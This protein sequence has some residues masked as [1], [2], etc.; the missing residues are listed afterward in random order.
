MGDE[1]PTQTTRDDLSRRLTK[2][3]APQLEP[4]PA[5]ATPHLVDAG[6]EVLGRGATILL[7]AATHVER[8]A[9]LERMR[10]RGD[11]PHV[12]RVYS[13]AQ[14]YYIGR[15]GSVDVVLTTCRAGAGSRDG[16]TIV[17]LEAIGKVRPRGVVAIGMAFGGYTNKLKI[18]DVLVSTRVIPYEAARIQEAGNISRGGEHD[19]GA[20]LLNRFSE[21]RG[22]TFPRG[23]GYACRV[24]DGPMLS[25]EKVVDSLRFKTDLF[26][27]H[28]QAIGGEMEGSGVHASSARRNLTEWIV[29]KAVCDWGDGSKNDGYQALAASTAV[30]LV[31][32]VFTPPKVL[33][34]LPPYAD[35]SDRAGPITV[36]PLVV[37]NVDSEIGTQN[38]IQGNATFL[39][40]PSSDIDGLLSN[41][42]TLLKKN[43]VPEAGTA[44]A[45]ADKLW[46]R[47]TTS[48]RAL[49]RAL[50]ARKKVLLGDYEGAAFDLHDASKQDPTGEKSASR[51][52]QALLL[53]D[54]KDE[55]YREAQV[56]LAASP[57]LPGV[58]Y[59]LIH[60][61][62]P[63][64]ETATLLPAHW[65]D[66]P[67]SSEVAV[68][69]FLREGTRDSALAEK[70]LR[71]VRE[72]AEDDAEYWFALG[73]TIENRIHAAEDRGDQIA[74]ETRDELMRAFARA[75][76]T[77]RGPD[78]DQQRGH[79]ALAI[80]V[81]A[82]RLGRL[83]ECERWFAL[84]K[85]LAPKSLAIR[86][87]RA[88]Q[89]F[90]Q[91]DYPTASSLLR[92]VVKSSDRPQR[93]RLV[94]A[95]SLLEQGTPATILEACDILDEAAS[96]ASDPVRDRRQAALLLVET[97]LDTDLAAAAA[98]I[99][100]HSAILRPYDADRLRLILAHES[101]G[102]GAGP[103]AAQM[104]AVR[105]EYSTKDLLDFGYVLGRLGLNVE[106]IEV[107]E[108]IAPRTELEP[109]TI[110]L[111]NAANAV[112]RFE[113]V[114]NI[115][116]S[117]RSVG[118]KD[119][120]ITDGE[121]TALAQKGDLTGALELGQR[122]M[123]EHPGDRRIRL[124][125][126]Q[127]AI[128]LGHFELLPTSS[129]ELPDVDT[130]PPE[131]A[132]QVVQVLRAANQ[133]LEAERLAYA[134]YKRRRRDKWAWKAVSLAGLPPERGRVT[135]ESDEGNDNDQDAQSV[136]IAGPGT[137]VRIKD[138]DSVRWIQVE[139][140]AEFATAEDE[141]AP[142]DPV[143]L[144][145][146]GKH[147]GD[148]VELQKARFGFPATHAV[149]EEIVSCFTRTWRHCNEQYALH[150]A[151]PSFVFSFQVPEP[152]DKLVEFLLAGAKERQESVASALRTYAERTPPIYLLADV[153]N[154]SVFEITP[155]LISEQITVHAAP[156][157]PTW[158]AAQDAL[159]R[160]KKIVIDATA[161]ATITMLG[162]IETS[163]TYFEQLWIARATLDSLRSHVVEAAANVAA[164]VDREIDVQGKGPHDWARVLAT[165]ETWD[166]FSE[167]E[168]D[169]LDSKSWDVWTKVAGAGTAE[170]VHR[171]K[172]LALPLW[173][174]DAAIARAATAEGVVVISTQAV[175]EVLEEA[176]RVDAG[177]L[178]EVGAAL[179]GWRFEPTRST[180]ASYLAATRLAKWDPSAR[181]LIQ[182]MELLTGLDAPASGVA[183]FTSEI[184]RL[185]WNNTIDRTAVDGLVVA[186]LIR[187]AARHDGESVITLLPEAVRLRFGL[188]VIGARHVSE[189][190]VGW[191]ETRFSHA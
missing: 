154:R 93:S 110:A 143:A 155:L 3:E 24:V 112:E 161:I 36:A 62:P 132:F 52:I 43:L 135:R 70:L 5:F 6:D 9:V 133:H 113:L 120:Q 164:C 188:D 68:A 123:N 57:S 90:N 91:G 150:F 60:A 189:V 126:S 83:E 141:F 147:V 144:A 25:G 86:T 181:P 125:L 158:K 171:A 76:A 82:R 89:S 84:A 190:I 17:T 180:P 114:A 38:I 134:N 176:G 55:A 140:V 182:H 96:D 129:A 97:Q 64:V 45:D 131:V 92:E 63:D 74:D 109:P 58:R 42:E 149:I 94:F 119:P 61:A 166:V 51:R 177:D 37:N 104:M 33:D 103:K 19:A 183:L 56:A 8:E 78:R 116:A 175:F 35:A 72:P 118:I 14:T 156:P 12:L 174:D 69:V 71:Q 65:K 102:A 20:V 39:T 1:Q 160:T 13:G 127:V 7:L 162:R 163:R 11:E 179:V 22:W 77:L 26:T 88:Q 31:E 151:E 4:R 79:I 73:V 152:I 191:A 124:R 34:A 80:A 23:D 44:I 130:S 185:W 117:L 81:N 99:D 66:E 40:H 2:G 168:R 27:D 105:S 101:D 59:L 128:E 41:I 139:E 15:L 50:R 100:R 148:R 49:L 153:L 167:A 108:H 87:E 18:G 172:R 75:Y 32:H 21:A 186:A 184:M 30:A 98:S 53:Q 28:P 136:R 106:C 173:I 142:T 121:M 122:W 138:G 47:M 115:C 10:P 178:A 169:A 16:S 111:L 170:S 137:A 157:P 107:L 145:V 187:I 95:K 29:V 165:A 159:R 48:Q 67:V 54:R 46:P 85:E 146:H